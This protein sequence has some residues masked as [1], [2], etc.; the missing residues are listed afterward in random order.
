MQSRSPVAIDASAP[1]R[2][3]P[4][5]IA[6]LTGRAANGVAG[7]LAEALAGTGRE[8][9]FLPSVTGPADLAEML[10]TL[11]GTVFVILCD[12]AD[13]AVARALRAGE[14]P[15]AALLAWQDRTGDLLH[16]V[17][18]HRRLVRLVDADRVAA[19]PGAFLDGFAGPDRATM[20]E[21]GAGD[22]PDPV[23]T[24]IA[25]LAVLL[26][27]AARRLGGELEA[28]MLAFGPETGTAYAEVAA[29]GRHYAALDRV[30]REG[31]DEADL[32]LLQMHA[33]LDEMETSHRARK[34]A[35]TRAARLERAQ[36]GE[37]DE[38]DLMMLQLLSLQD[39]LERRHTESRD[40]DARQAQAGHEAEALHLRLAETEAELARARDA[41]AGLEQR[42]AESE[43]RVRDL[44]AST[45]WKVTEPLRWVKTRMDRPDRG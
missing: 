5:R 41:A 25:R 3:G 33:L 11:P 36:A 13:A 26:S 18:R 23:E 9:R 37:H 39:E 44:L 45:S 6:D 31:R 22:P 34:A 24:A 8:A 2:A 17:R 43:T 28:S 10:A 20:P 35:E 14:A 27:P 1:G 40:R 21:I 38:L 30:L 42:L 19:A 12:R 7:A 16:E 32:A 15:D 4:V 29:A